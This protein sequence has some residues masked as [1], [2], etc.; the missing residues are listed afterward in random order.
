MAH[1]AR[2]EGL[3]AAEAAEVENEWRQLGA[4]GIR[5]IAQAD[6]LFTMTCT[7][8]DPPFATTD[9]AE[10]AVAQSA[11][12]GSSMIEGISTNR[13]CHSSA[14]CL[15]AAGKQFVF[16]YHSR[17]TQQPQKRLS[18]KE[19]AEL[20][21]AG[22]DVAA[23]Y[24]DRGRTEADF[25]AARGFEDGASA[26]VY[27][28]QVG[29][30]PDS[31]VYFAVDADFSA[32]QLHSAVVPYFR[33]VKSAFDR[34]GKGHANYRIGVYGSGLT[35]RLLTEELDFIAFTWLAEATG[36]RESRTYEAWTVRQHLNGGDTL[37]QLGSDFERCEARGSFGQFK[38]VGF[39]LTRGQGELRSVAA[40]VL[41][42]RHAPTTEFNTPAAQL[43][44]NHGVRVLGP[45]APG[46]LRV[47]TELNG[48]DLIGH[49]SEAL[50]SPA[51]A[52]PPAPLLP[53]E[54]PVPAVHLRENN[55][56]ARR[57][58]ADARAFP[59]GEAGR[60]VRDSGADDATQCGQLRLLADWLDVETSL[61]YRRTAVTFCNVYA[62]DYCYL[63]Q[64]YLPRVWW[65]EPAL[66]SIGAG[67]MP[68][69]VVGQT[70]REMRADDLHRWLI[71]FGAQFGWRRVFDAT[72][73]QNCANAGGVGV[74]CADRDAEGKPGHIT[75]V[76]PE[77]SSHQAQR[78]PDGHV[79]QP[80]Q[81]Q[82]GATNHRYGSAGPG[83]WLDPMFR[84]FVF[85]V[86]D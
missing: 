21:R 27:A 71:E 31:A 77:D 33:A 19:A 56:A 63:A 65:T 4:T 40:N 73:L 78:D 12:G 2:I 20:A 51:D 49:V 24:Q 9:A 54:R 39:A 72:A 37:C 5:R 47:R 74:I 50:L 67:Q 76:V 45:S 66:M 58:S 75:V 70:V 84:S 35:C 14:D 43:P 85:F 22:L 68:P 26:V 83:W 80:L 61:R 42:L 57:A 34:A 16:R 79:V 7:F 53:V 36:W 18:P 48:A 29:Q 64:V 10:P 28:G 44:Q 52:V 59:L 60:P 15:L 25:G 38:P 30:P 3:S 6:G 69:V 1:D 55:A 62:A 46:W 13:H 81:S 11:P 41:N 8:P 82:A 86:H 17:T 23:V 32:A